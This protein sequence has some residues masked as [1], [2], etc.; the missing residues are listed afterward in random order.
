MSG[1]IVKVHGDSGLVK[2]SMFRATEGG[3]RKMIAKDIVRGGWGTWQEGQR[4]ARRVP[5]PGVK[6]FKPGRFY[7]VTHDD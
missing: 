5:I 2:E 1:W 4:F 7:E 3:V 6:G